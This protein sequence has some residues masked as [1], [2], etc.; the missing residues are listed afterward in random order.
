MVAAALVEGR[1]TLAEV[2]DEKVKDPKILKMARKVTRIV[3]PS[4]EDY[5][6]ASLSIK[7][8]DGNMYHQDRKAALGSP[9]MP[10]PREMI[11]DKF[12]ANVDGILPKKRAQTVMDT[13]ANLEGLH[14]VSELMNLLRKD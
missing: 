9:D 1:A 6:S 14:R 11:E 12:L 5:R 3:D 4:F 8:K 2:S 13:V 10:A 7:M